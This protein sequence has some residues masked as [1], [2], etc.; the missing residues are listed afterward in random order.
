MPQL[1]VEICMS[2]TY[3]APEIVVGATVPIDH[4]TTPAG[5]QPRAPS[6][7]V[8]SPFFVRVEALQAPAYVAIGNAPD[9]T[10]EPRMLVLPQ[11][12]GAN[13]PVV[14][15]RPGESVAAILAEDIE[16]S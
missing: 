6:G 15:I 8:A 3:Q 2:D 5:A 9:P 13:H 10:R 4:L 16:A 11:P 1:R 12:R 14:R 7:N